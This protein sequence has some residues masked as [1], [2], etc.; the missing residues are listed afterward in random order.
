M[1]AVILGFAVAFV[2][3]HAL[4]AGAMTGK[5]LS[6][7]LAGGKD[8]TLGG[9]TEGYSGELHV[10]KDGSANGQVK[11][12]SG[13]VIPIEGKWE[14]KGNKFCRTWKGGRDAGKEICETWVKSGPNTVHAMNGK[15]DL[16][17]NSWH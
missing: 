10:M 9:P 7:L 17:V 14:I 4:A 13:D 16:G 8:L 3:S 5:E 1:R 2:G 15:K 12:K 6:A 11:L